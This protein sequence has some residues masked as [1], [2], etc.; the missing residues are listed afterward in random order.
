[1][2]IHRYF[3][4]FALL[5]LGWS[6]GSGAAGAEDQRYTMEVCRGE[7]DC[8]FILDTQ[9]GEVR[10]CQA[11]GCRVLDDG[12]DDSALP[13]V[14]SNVPPA[15]TPSP[16]EKSETGI[17]MRPPVRA[18]EPLPSPFPEAGQS[19]SQA[20]AATPAKP[21]AGDDGM[22]SPFPISGKT[23]GQALHQ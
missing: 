13:P 22:P 10:F 12:Q 18:G 5:A 9:T 3:A 15:V 16:S 4:L 6:I 14:V 20:P 8:A 21:A 11:I 23:T 17:P 19:A 7:T 2:R 1:M